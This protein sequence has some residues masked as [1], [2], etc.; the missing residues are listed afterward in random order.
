MAFYN[1]KY[2]KYKFKNMLGGYKNIFDALDEIFKTYR[3]EDCRKSA[4]HSVYLLKTVLEEHRV[5]PCHGIEHAKVVMYHAF[6]ALE[7]YPLLEHENKLAVL[8]AA[9]LH[10]ADDGKFFPEN[11]DYENLRKILRDNGKTE[12]FI[13]RVAY[14]VSIVSASKNGDNIPE[15]IAGNEWLLIPRYADRL[16]AIGFIG[17]E[18][19]KTYSKKV[20]DPVYIESTPRPRSEEEIWGAATKE[21]Y[22][23]YAKG[24]KS[25]S[26]I[27]HYYDKLLR[28]SIF[29]ITNTYFDEQ[30]DIRR[31]PLINFLIWFGNREEDTTYED[32]DE[33]IMS[34]SG[35]AS[36]SHE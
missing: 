32:I 4:E 3:D 23:R 15:D 5:S 1:K 30:C 27:D 33:Y 7:D 16:E 24:I 8:M 13:N 19:C 28:L 21:R 9:L 34:N 26:M 14:M 12:D 22:E 35:H 31:Q 2:L 10:D 18:R 20:R 6:N 36:H 11:H 29:P 25:L 17:I